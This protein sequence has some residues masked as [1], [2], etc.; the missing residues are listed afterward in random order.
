MGKPDIK[1]YTL[2]PDLKR[3]FLYKKSVEFSYQKWF[4]NSDGSFKGDQPG[5]YPENRSIVDADFINHFFS[6]PY[7]DRTVLVGSLA[8]IPTYQDNIAKFC[9]IDADCQ[10]EKDLV[11]NKILPLYTQY[12]IDYVIEHGGNNNERCHI[13]F[14]VDDIPIS[15]LQRFV[16]QIF[17][18]AE[19]PIGRDGIQEIYP[20]NK[21]S[22]LIRLWGGPHIKRG[23]KRFPIEYKGEIYEDVID[24][25]KVF[26][27]C[28]LLTEEKLSSLL[29]KEIVIKD[30]IK[31]KSKKYKSDYEPLNFRSRELET[32]EGLPCLFQQTAKECQAI[33]ITL[34]D[35]LENRMPGKGLDEQGDVN[36]MRSLFLHSMAEYSAE[37]L[38]KNDA[39]EWLQEQIEL[40][41]FRDPTSHH[42]EGK[43]IITGCKAWEN[44]VGLCTGCPFQGRIDS[45]QDL[46]YGKPITKMPVRDVALKTVE[47]IRSTTFIRVRNE[48][49]QM[50]N[51]G[52][53]GNILIASPLGS[54]KSFFVAQT[55]ANLAKQ[56]K[57]I[58]I[59]VPT[60]E[61]ALQF[62]TWLLS[63]GVKPFLLMSH[64]AVFGHQKDPPKKSSLADFDCPF[65]EEIEKQKDLGIPSDSFKDQFCGKCPFAEK[66]YYPEQYTQVHEDEYKVVIIQHAHFGCKE[67]IF[68][69]M[70]KNFDILFV[71]ESFIQQIYQSVEIKMAEIEILKHFHF[72]WSDNFLNWLQS[73][74]KAI[75]KIKPL[76]Q[77]LEQIKAVYDSCGFE[78]KIPNY[79]R[80]YNQG[81]TVNKYTGIEIISELP[82]IPIKVFTDATP[83]TA[84][85]EG[86]T[87]LGTIKTYGDNEV[88]DVKRIHPNNEV[89]Q[90][91][92]TSASFTS[93]E[94]DDR[95]NSLLTLIG[96]FVQYKYNGEKI[97]LTVRNA[98]KPR[99][100]SFFENH[101]RYKD[102][103]SRI[104]I[105]IL[106]KG[107]NT[108]EDY[109]IQFLM[110]GIYFLGRDYAL[111][112]YKYKTAYN[113]HR[114]RMGLKEEVNM[115][116]I[117]R[118]DYMKVEIEP[119]NITRIEKIENR[120]ILN[121]YDN[122][123]NYIPTNKWEYLI[124]QH[125]VANTQQ[126]VRLR[127][128][129]DKR[130]IVV[131]LNNSSFPSLLVTQSVLEDELLNCL[132]ATLEY[133]G[134]EIKA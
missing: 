126:A 132:T 129:P 32:P 36:H 128:K 84:L 29:K 6:H 110:T 131:V 90:V 38:K 8:F 66:C 98:Q 10:R 67:I 82:N 13:W 14:L 88:L 25:I 121:S 71:D 51:T 94:K 65:F 116:P 1:F 9:V 62:R 45:I 99:I 50:I 54:G 105:N 74:T 73:K 52:Q 53:K 117:N 42:W 24:M 104:T 103:L 96:Y 64:A 111:D 75:G 118:S 108:Y 95:I 124:Y 68:D 78:W 86:I 92:D 39:R 19:V 100:I 34:R 125:N 115:Y 56:N 120:G 44:R 134:T 35:I 72:S 87:G 43:P 47:E 70:R 57:N 80:Y 18:E 81:R 112:S 5:F 123:F 20:I 93:L 40:G 3:R 2:L 60:G 17:A 48:I 55:A 23:G 102:V 69:L 27:S 77:Q 41:R 28:R 83:P 91:L 85:I 119:F 122:F 4:K 114:Q 7:E 49:N 97:L 15:L 16:K 22:N 21:A 101:E 61:I 31:T 130:R 12:G 63:Q 59:A 76:E 127:F 109:D 33:N 113:Y 30:D 133:T 11:F 58:L 107:S 46:R 89:I 37:R 79:L 26:T 106:E